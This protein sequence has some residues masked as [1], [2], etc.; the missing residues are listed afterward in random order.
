MAT[1]AGAYVK[2]LCERYLAGQPFGEFW[3]RFTDFVGD[4]VDHADFT[5]EQQAAFDDLY[6]H[7]YMARAG[8]PTPE[9][10]RDGL[11]R[12]DDLRRYLRAFRWES[13]GAPGA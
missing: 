4:E 6:E 1:E 9:G 2:E 8:L 7:I 12:E 10:L 11:T 13:I 3:A 5:A